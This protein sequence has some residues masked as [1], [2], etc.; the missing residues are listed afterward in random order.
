MIYDFLFLNANSSMKNKFE[1]YFFNTDLLLVVP[2]MQS[3]V[4]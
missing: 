1:C 2:S 3:G 4:Q